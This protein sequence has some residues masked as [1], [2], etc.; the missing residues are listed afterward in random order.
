M[1]NI[2]KQWHYILGGESISIDDCIKLKPIDQYLWGDVW[3][4][5]Y[6]RQDGKLFIYSEWY[7]CNA[8]LE[9]CFV[10]YCCI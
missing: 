6:Q 10:E 4:H 2:R 8:A 1:K 3:Y 7:S 5:L 9:G